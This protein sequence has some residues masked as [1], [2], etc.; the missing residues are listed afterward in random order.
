LERDFLPE[1][2]GR[3]SLLGV[4]AVRLAF[5]W[6]IDAAETDAFSAL[7]VQAIEV[8]LCRNGFSAAS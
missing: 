1:G 2:E 7:V 8:L 5:L 3:G 6:A 4:V